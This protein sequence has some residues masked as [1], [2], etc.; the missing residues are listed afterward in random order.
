M[1]ENTY[2]IV[3]GDRSG[4]FFGRIDARDGREVRMTDCRCLWYW[5]GAATLLQLAREGVKDQR[6]SK[7]TMSVGSLTILDAIELIP[8]TQEAVDNIRGVTEWKMS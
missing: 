5:N 2:Y 1:E 7:F 8:C 3:R 6:G 4:V